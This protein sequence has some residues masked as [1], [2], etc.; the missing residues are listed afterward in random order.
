MLITTILV[1]AAALVLAL[2]GDVLLS[3][4]PARPEPAL[5][6]QSIW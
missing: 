5:R 3:P 2:F 1:A 4:E 6:G